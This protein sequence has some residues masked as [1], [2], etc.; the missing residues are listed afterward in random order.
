MVRHH[1]ETF[2]GSGYPDRLKGEHIPLGA[3]ILAVAD[4]F[5][6]LVSERSYKRQRTYG[7]AVVEL[8]RCSG[9]Q[10]D[11]RLIES[12]LQASDGLKALK[13]QG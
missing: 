10:F 13:N 8:Y 1:H 11:P 9:K 6:T 7:D 12:L 4:S 5:D 2:D 3:R